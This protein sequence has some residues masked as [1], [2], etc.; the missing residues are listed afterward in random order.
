[1]PRQITNVV[2]PFLDNSSTPV[3]SLKASSRTFEPLS[4]L[5]CIVTFCLALSKEKIES[6][7]E[8]NPYMPWASLNYSSIAEC[9]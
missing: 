1:V 5:T 6:I 7:G 2:F 8:V 3:T 9:E 4:F